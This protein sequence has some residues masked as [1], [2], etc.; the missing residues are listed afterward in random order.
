MRSPYPAVRV[1]VN[2]ARALPGAPRGLRLSAPITPETAL[3]IARTERADDARRT[4]ANLGEGSVWGRSVAPVT[5]RKARKSTGWS[6]V[7]AGG[8]Y[9]V[10]AGV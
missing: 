9:I 5:G 10:A 4:G 1:P 6:T 3:R 8:E 7:V 2:R